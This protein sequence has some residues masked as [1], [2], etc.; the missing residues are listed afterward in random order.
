MEQFQLD[1]IYHKSL[2][3]TF[4]CSDQITVLNHFGHWCIFLLKLLSDTAL[5]NK[6]LR[7]AHLL[8]FQQEKK[9][10]GTLLVITLQ[11]CSLCN[12]LKFS[13]KIIIE[14]RG[15]G[16]NKLSFWRYSSVKQFAPVCFKVNFP[17]GFRQIV[18]SC[19]VQFNIGFHLLTLY[20]F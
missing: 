13:L 3:F 5:S 1:R 19:L 12:H 15:K 7:S 6:S 4:H 18:C 16:C 17:D 10:A 2:P 20:F 11:E 8:K 14:L 9:F